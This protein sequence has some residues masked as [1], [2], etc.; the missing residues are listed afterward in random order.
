MRYIALLLCLFTQ[1]VWAIPILTYHN[2]DPSTPGSMTI[3]TAKFE[4]QLKWLKDNG[5]TV[6]PLQEVLS[7]FSKKTGPLPAKSVAITVDDGKASVYTY[8]YPIVKKYQVPVT[9]FVYPS[10]I[11]NASYAM[12]WEQLKTLQETELFDIQS[13]T[14][15]HPNFKTEKK[16]LSKDDYDKF[17][18]HQ[19]TQSRKS[20]EKKMEAPVNMLAWPFGI[21]DEQLEEAAHRAG[22]KMAFSIDGRPASPSENWMS[23]PRYMITQGQSL[24]TFIKMVEGENIKAPNSLE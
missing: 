21:Y 24:E 3:S 4:E 23:Q 6:V 10:A 18:D 2:F 22:Y 13:H 7:S 12:T 9:L 17:I 1:C 14:Y 19:L 8:M 15:W 5:Y 20:I 16:R 11:S